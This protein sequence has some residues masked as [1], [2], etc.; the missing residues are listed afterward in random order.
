MALLRNEDTVTDITRFITLEEKQSVIRTEWQTLDGRTYL[1]RYGEPNTTYEIV[2]YV[3][4]AGKHLLFEAEDTA[5]LL[6]AECKRGT[7]YG[8]IIELKEFS[9]LAGDWYKTTLTLAPKVT[10]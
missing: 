1:Q 8:H 9:H 5:A 3:N 6:K 7:F 4:Y 2:A 10:E